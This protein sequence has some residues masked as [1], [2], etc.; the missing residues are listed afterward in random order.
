MRAQLAFVLF[1]QLIL[2]LF[3]ETRGSQPQSSCL[4]I[5]LFAVNSL[6]MTVCVLKPVPDL[7]GKF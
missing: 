2:L 5:R 3:L 4:Y 6:I 7:T 1:R